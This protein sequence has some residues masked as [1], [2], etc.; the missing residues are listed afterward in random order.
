MLIGL[1][2]DAAAVDFGAA[3]VI[4]SDSIADQVHFDATI[5]DLKNI[6]H[7]AIA[8]SLSDIAAMGG[9]PI[10][11]T[12]DFFLPRD[13]DFNQLKN[14]FTSM[15]ATASR[16]ETQIVAGDTNRWDN[17]LVISTTAM[18]IS[19]RAEDRSGE[20]LWKLSGGK[21]G[22]I[23]CV[24]GALG[25]SILGKHLEFEPRVNLAI[26]LA[27]RCEI[28][29]ATDITDSLATDLAAIARASKCGFRLNGGDIPVDNA[30]AQLSK[31]DGGSPLEHALF[32][33]EDFE[34]VL[35]MSCLLYTSPSP[36]DQRGSRMPSSA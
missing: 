34:L 25:G 29:A 13:L 10:A 2:D 16:F 4:T 12:I 33:G 31:Q 27:Q 22:D 20:H 24:T 23:V 35:C 28:H 3:T 36:R 18:G 14:L 19:A 9:R 1:G 32:D 5:H 30:A 17:P 7:K 8:V 21:P 26:E 6:G 11:L 15:A